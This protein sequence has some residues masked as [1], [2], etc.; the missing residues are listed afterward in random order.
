[1][2]TNY[3]PIKIAVLPSPPHLPLQGTRAGSVPQLECDKAHVITHLCL[4]PSAQV[5]S[6]YVRT[7]PLRTSLVASIDPLNSVSSFSPRSETN[8]GAFLPYYRA[9]KLTRRKCR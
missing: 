8:V 5:T 4:L 7:V 1:M 6:S 2:W 3:D 9:A